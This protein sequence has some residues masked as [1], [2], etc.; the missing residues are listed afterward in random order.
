MERI[1]QLLVVLLLLTSCAGYKIRDNNNPFAAADVHSLA[2]P[3]FINKT[4]FERVAYNYTRS[5][6][7]MLS[8]FKNLKISTQN[9][10][11]EDAVL[12]GVIKPLTPGGRVERVKTTSLMTDA[13]TDILKDKRRIF[14]VPTSGEYLFNVEI[15]I[16]KRPTKE[17]IE[18]FT[19]DLDFDL[20]SFPR[21]IFSHTIRINNSYVIENPENET[22][23]KT[24]GLLGVQNRGRLRKSLVDSAKDF[25]AELREV[26]SN[27]F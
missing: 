21:L 14:E 5:T 17:E 4:T 20:S 18:F 25:S 26:I 22:E 10:E 8:D 9:I 13:Q 12:L 2:V 16:L 6:I 27:A 15:Y 19:K 23:A 24:V 11:N 7:E 1:F 3:M